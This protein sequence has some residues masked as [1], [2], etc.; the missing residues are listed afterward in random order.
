LILE[1]VNHGERY[2]VH[3]VDYGNTETVRVSCIKD[4]PQYCIVDLPIQSILVQGRVKPLKSNNWSSSLNE[5]MKSL[6]EQNKILLAKFSL[7]KVP[8]EVDL[9]EADTNTSKVPFK[10]LFQDLINQGQLIIETD[11]N[12]ALNS[13]RH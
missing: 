12:Y 10:S 13:D 3:F 2:K 9:F 1:E 5:S 8:F 7:N 6:L 11:E 4:L